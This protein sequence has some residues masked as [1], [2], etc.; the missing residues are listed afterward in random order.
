[1]LL[2]IIWP[3]KKLSSKQE[4]PS[5]APK[6][7]PCGILL[8]DFKR[9]WLGREKALSFEAQATKTSEEFEVVTIQ[10]IQEGAKRGLII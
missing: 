9:E 5:S 1:M 3:L 7:K 4:N 2:T 8:P 10:A 6:V